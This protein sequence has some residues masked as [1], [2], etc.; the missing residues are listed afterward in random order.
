MKFVD[1]QESPEMRD[2]K[3]YSL[4]KQGPLRHLAAAE[5][6]R[7]SN[8]APSLIPKRC[9]GKGTE[10]L[11]VGALDASL[12]KL[13]NLALRAATA[14]ARLLH[15]GLQ[16]LCCKSSRRSLWNQNLHHQGRR[17]CRCPPESLESSRCSKEPAVGRRAEFTSSKLPAR[18]HFPA[19]WGQLSLNHELFH[20]ISS[21]NHLH[22]L[23]TFEACLSAQTRL[24]DKLQALESQ[25]QSHWVA[26]RM[27]LG[28]K[29]AIRNS[30]STWKDTRPTGPTVN[31]SPF[32]RQTQVFQNFRC[33]HLQLQQN[34]RSLAL[35]LHLF[36]IRFLRCPV[37]HVL[38]LLSVSFGYHAWNFVTSWPE[39]KSL[40]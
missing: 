10:A 20:I 11:N 35:D 25:T 34:G 19:E 13:G 7:P 3:T 17:L 23:S 22:I 5:P 2:T 1:V 37:T 27:L 36:G 40:W 12:Q 14:A 21:M 9:K 39:N 31:R 18:G 15:E 4:L 30:L 38:C 6:I 33:S 32:T 26:A 28:Y 24:H 16:K 29:H 8:F